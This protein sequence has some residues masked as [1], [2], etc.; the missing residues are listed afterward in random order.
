MDFIANYGN[1]DSEDD[2]DPRSASGV[3][4]KRP[5]DNQSDR[6]L[7]KPPTHPITGRLP[8]PFTDLKT[9]NE[10][11]DEPALHNNRVR[12]F[13]HER[14][15]WATFVHLSWNISPKLIDNINSILLRCQ[16]N[17]VNLTVSD[18]FHIS[19]TRTVVLR[20]HWI[21]G[22][23]SS[24]R[25]QMEDIS[26][27][28][29]YLQDLAVFVNEER[30]RTFLAF[31]LCD[32]SNTLNCLV[33]QLNSILQEYQ[34]QTFYEK[35]SHHMSFAWCIGDRKQELDYIISNYNA[36]C[37]LITDRDDCQ[38]TEVICKTGNLKFSYPL[39]TN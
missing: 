16:E 38:F 30:T 17:N 20:H 23:N 7:K 2:A 26:S 21:E 31:Q 33:Q 18:D 10:H 11:Q 5:L 28:S 34:L 35:P 39:R 37:S 22:F 9:S 36:T 29:L 1:S 27:F 25:K 32:N 12:S 3:S 13:P 19:L 6:P 24:V 8:A 4:I 15:N 14:G